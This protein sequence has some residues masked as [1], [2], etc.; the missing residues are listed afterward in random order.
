M[1]LFMATP[2]ERQHSQVGD[3]AFKAKSRHAMI[4]YLN[5]A[6]LLFK[7]SIQSSKMVIMPLLSGKE[8]FS[9]TIMFIFLNVH[10]G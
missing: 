1:D 2:N 8:S 9:L 5:N 3:K 7:N 6:G 10:T 4:N